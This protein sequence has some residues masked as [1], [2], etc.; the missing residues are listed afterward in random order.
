HSPARREKEDDQ[1]PQRAAA[2]SGEHRIGD[3]LIAGADDWEPRRSRTAER[4]RA[5]AGSASIDQLWAGAD[6][7]VVNEPR[8]TGDLPVFEEPREAGD[9]PVFEEPRETGDLAAADEPREAGDLE[10]A[11]EPGMDAAPTIADPARDGAGVTTLDPPR[12]EA[13]PHTR[14]RRAST[15]S[16]PA[17]ADAGGA[18]VPGRRTVTIRGRGAER[19]VPTRPTGTRRPSRRRYERAGFRPDRAAMWAVLL[20]VMLILVAVTSAHAAILH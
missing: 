19:Y 5:R 8:G 2:P 6:F 9:L 1:M 3:W 13:S 11:A 20:G 4:R 15:T 17:P 14:T 10:S 7:A 12:T 16:G 18:G